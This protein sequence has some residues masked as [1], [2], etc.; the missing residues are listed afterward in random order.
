MLSPKIAFFFWDE[1]SMGKTAR[2]ESQVLVGLF[3]AALLVHLAAVTHHWTVPHLAG[4]EFRQTQTAITTY[5]IDEQNNFSLLYETP[6]LGKPWV[7]ILMEVPIYEWSVVGLSRLTHLPHFLAARTISL[8]CFYLMLPALYLLLGRLGLARSRRLLVLALVLTCPVYIYYSRAFLMDSM[9]LMFSAWF[10]LGFVRTMDER[11]WPWLAVAVA[12]GTGAALIKSAILAVWLW[13]AAG[14]G[15]WM[16]WRDVRG[17]GGWRVAAKTVLWGAATVVVAFGTLR[18]WIVYTDPLKAAHDSAWIF[19]SRNLAEGNW[20]LFDFKSILSSKVW[21]DLLGGWDQAIMSRWLIGLLLVA[22][23]A[24]PPS[25]RAVLAFGGVFLLAQAMFPFA[26]AYQ[27][28]YFYACAIFLNAAT[29]CVLLALLD[30]RLPRWV[31]ALVCLIPF[32]AQLTAYRQGYWITQ[33]TQTQAGFPFMEALRDLTPRDSVIVVAGAD[34]AAMTP[35]YAQRKALMVRNGLEWDTA[36]LERAFGRLAGEK[37]SA[38][39]VYSDVRSNRGFIALAARH[40]GFDPA[41]PTFSSSFADIYV[42]RP[43]RKNLQLRLRASQRYPQLTMPKSAEDGLPA[44]GRLKLSP[45]TGRE[46]FFNV[47]PAPFEAE[48]QYGLS[49]IEHGDRAVILAHPD[50]DLWLKPPPEATK[51]RWNYGVVGGRLSESRR[52]HQ[53]R[54]I[55]RRG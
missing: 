40:F 23:L 26:Y 18:A 17:G 55:H 3:F 41:A 14:Y 35:Y 13:P 9:A 6:I 25:R 21:G 10:L 12:A 54:G 52:A 11:R 49:W 5:Y 20:G 30:S 22:G 45:E 32:A 29:G 48:F 39:V 46:V 42:T 16:L 27:D 28:Y 50:S 8:A 34:W 53:R 47:A 43:Y 4:H 7:S 31:G 33:H 2:R 19:T 44:K 51:I 24:F 36:Y 1:M 15:A 38:V 37:V